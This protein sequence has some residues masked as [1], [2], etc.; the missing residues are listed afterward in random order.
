MSDKNLLLF[1]ITGI[2]AIMILSYVLFP[3]VRRLANENTSELNTADQTTTSGKVLTTENQEMVK[4]TPDYSENIS[5]PKII[6]MPEAD[7]Q[8]RVNQAI[9]DFILGPVADFEEQVMSEDIFEDFQDYLQIQYLVTLL[10]ESLVSISFSESQNFGGAHPNNY[11][12][13]FNYDIAGGEKFELKDIFKKEVDYQGIISGICREKLL[14][15]FGEDEALGLWI[16]EGTEPKAGN[17]ENFGLTGGSLVIYF[18]PY[19]V[20]PY[21]MG[22]QTVEITFAEIEQYLD[23]EGLLKDLI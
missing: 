23:T 10:N 15:Q 5:Y 4:E 12:T 13:N 22:I 1:G 21:A 20:G 19:E 3:G 8:E 7:V 2:I 11:T 14:A 17:F 18:N 9:A 6:N 16:N